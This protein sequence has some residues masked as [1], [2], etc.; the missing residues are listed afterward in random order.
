MVVTKKARALP[1]LRAR[2]RAGSLAYIIRAPYYWVVLVS[3]RGPCVTAYDFTWCEH[4]QFRGEP[5]AMAFITDSNLV[6]AN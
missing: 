6:I 1:A 2:P 5:E 3:T 4:Y